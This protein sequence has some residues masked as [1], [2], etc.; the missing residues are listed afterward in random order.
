MTVREAISWELVALTAVVVG[1]GIYAVHRSVIVPIHHWI[2]CLF[3]WIGDLLLR[4]DKRESGNPTRWLG[5]LGVPLLCRISAYTALR[6]SDLFKQERTDWN[7]AHA[8]AG[9]VL[10]TFEGFL[11]AAFYAWWKPAPIA[12]L[13]LAWVAG[14]LLVFS[15][16]SFVQHA[17]EC[18]RLRQN[19][20]EVR[21]RCASL[22][23]CLE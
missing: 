19:E 21:R 1:A 22:V 17:V 9:L 8:E 10:M 12:W 3:W 20:A 13:P 5:H 16:A 4:K 15:F 2:M 11:L 23:C 14:L 6:R 7:I 18:R